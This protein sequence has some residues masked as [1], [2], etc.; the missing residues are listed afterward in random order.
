VLASRQTQH[1]H[2]LTSGPRERHLRHQ[3][4]VASA[5]SVPYSPSAKPPTGLTAGLATPGRPRRIRS[6]PTVKAFQ[7]AGQIAL[8]SGHS[9]LER[10]HNAELGCTEQKTSLP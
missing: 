4:H 8:P 7:Q 1:H 10:L 3:A 6:F 5:S 2:S 9:Y